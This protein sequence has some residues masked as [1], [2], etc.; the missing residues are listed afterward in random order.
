MK[1]IPRACGELVLLT[2]IPIIVITPVIRTSQ[3]ADEH[4]F[5]V[6]DMKI[7]TRVHVKNF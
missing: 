5:V 3:L 7:E 6:R 2:L 1:W 4:I